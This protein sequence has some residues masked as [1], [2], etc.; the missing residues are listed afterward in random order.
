MFACTASARF[1]PLTNTPLAAKEY[2]TG[3]SA[4]SLDSIADSHARLEERMDHPEIRIGDNIA[5]F[6]RTYTD[7]VEQTSRG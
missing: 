6:E 1:V 4:Q 5:V 7:T 3:D 2:S